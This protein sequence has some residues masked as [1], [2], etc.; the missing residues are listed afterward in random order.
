MPLNLIVLAIIAAIILI[1]VIAFTVGGAGTTFS[2]IGKAGTGATGDEIDTIRNNCRAACG[3]AQNTVTDGGEWKQSRYCQMRSSIDLDASGSLNQANEKN[4]RCWD[5]AININCAF[6]F[7]KGGTK[8]IDSE[9]L[10][11]IG[12]DCA[13]TN[14]QP[15]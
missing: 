12:Q 1:L 6:T 13:K 2:R 9:S 4:I 8:K 7:D 15:V 11:G 14:V 5:A 10:P 3:N